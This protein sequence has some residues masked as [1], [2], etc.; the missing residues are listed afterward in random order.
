MTLYDPVLAR[1]QK[2][3]LNNAGQGYAGKTMPAEEV[4]GQATTMP[5]M[6]IP[7]T[8]KLGKTIGPE[9][10]QVLVEVLHLHG[11]HELAV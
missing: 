11:I 7:E 4:K 2:A 6:V 3:G 8:E 1:K 9:E 5:E 10:Q